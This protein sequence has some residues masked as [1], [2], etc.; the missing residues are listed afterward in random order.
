M[1]KTFKYLI[2]VAAFMSLQTTCNNND[3]PP[4]NTDPRDKFVGNWT[5][6]ETSTLNKKGTSSYTVAISLNTGNSSQ[7][8]LAN[9]YGLGSAKTVYAVV[10]GDVATIPDQSISGT[11]GFSA[12]GS[13]SITSSDTKINWDYYVNDGAEIDTCSAVFS[14]Q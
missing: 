11:T 7:I 10:A 6:V 1:K 3:N 8:D 2:I 5:C 13:G 14:K 4:D 9:F 12:K